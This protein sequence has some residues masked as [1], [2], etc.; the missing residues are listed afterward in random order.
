MWFQFNK[1]LKPNVILFKSSQE[2][3]TL[4]AV[5]GLVFL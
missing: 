2:T 5:L 1:M 4:L 3:I